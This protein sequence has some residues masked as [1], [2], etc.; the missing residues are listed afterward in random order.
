L[1]HGHGWYN[2]HI[3]NKIAKFFIV[4]LILGFL[5]FLFQAYQTYKV[6]G[7]IKQSVDSGQ[8]R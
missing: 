1:I 5:G 6:V 8:N 4:L 3:M 7:E 2:L